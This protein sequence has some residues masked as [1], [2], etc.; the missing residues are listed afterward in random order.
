MTLKTVPQLHDE[1]DTQFPTNATGQI[2]ASKLRTVQHDLVDSLG[3]G[4]TFSGTGDPGL[5]AAQ[6][7]TTFFTAPPA[8]INTSGYSNPGD[9]GGGQYVRIGITPPLHSGYK[10]SADGSVYEL[11]LQIVRSIFAS[12]AQCQC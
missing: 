11:R 3:S 6:I 1:I 10:V 7:E 4:G 12:L 8:V 9:S 5:T 2:T